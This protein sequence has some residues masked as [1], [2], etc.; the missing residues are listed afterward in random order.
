M[1]T[2]HHAIKIQA[3]R[4]KVYR[5][6]TD[7]A[8]MGQWHLGEVGG[9]IAPGSTLTLSPRAGQ[10]FSWRTESL[11]TDQA[12]V[13]TCTEGAG[14]SAGKQL[15]FTLSDLPGGLTLVQLSDGEWHEGDPHRAFCNTHWGDVL[16]R[17]KNFTEE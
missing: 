15:S 3:P 11:Q 10:R 14:S 8:Q 17:L 6:L 5:A 13:Q 16:N 9:E 1:S 7:I 2:L 12:I 4:A